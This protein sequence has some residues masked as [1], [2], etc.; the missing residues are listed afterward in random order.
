MKGRRS[1]AASCVEFPQQGDLECATDFDFSLMTFY[2]NFLKTNTKFSAE[3]ITNEVVEE[4]G[5]SFVVINWVFIGEI[6]FLGI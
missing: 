1:V 4:E 6:E 5:K 3:I 2:K